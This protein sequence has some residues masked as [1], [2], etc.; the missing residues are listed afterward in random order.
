MFRKLVPIIGVI[1]GLAL[2]ITANAQQTA[3]EI[4]ATSREYFSDT[5]LLN[6]DGDEV[7]FYSDVLKDQI[8]VINFIFTSCQGAC[9]LITQKLRMAR[10][11]LGEEASQKIRFVSISIDPTRDTPAALREF[12]KKQQADGDWVFLTGIPDNVDHVVKKLGQYFPDV[13]EHSTLLIAGNV[14]TRPWMKIPPQVPAQG[15]AEKLRELI[16]G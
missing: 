1:A 9:P 4:D 8:V 5:S 13:E 12:A 3:E 10:D 16:D 15:V 2:A 7:Q 14:K 6:Q 11:E